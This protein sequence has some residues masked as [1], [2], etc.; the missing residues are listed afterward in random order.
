MKHTWINCRTMLAHLQLEDYWIEEL[1]FRDVGLPSSDSPSNRPALP[2]VEFTVSP[3]DADD[4][5]QVFFVGLRVV[6]GKAQVLRGVP[7]EFRIQV[8]GVF[9]VS[10]D[11]KDE[12]ARYRLV[13]LNGPAMLYGIARSAI[14]TVT[15]MGHKTKYIL[16]SI[17]II[18]VWKRQQR[19][20]KRLAPER[21]ILD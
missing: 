19:R 16:P 14:G 12:A 13:H 20:A 4:D 21:V 7:Y 15:A 6:A 5:E 2:R 1:T 11:V 9:T 17:N 3:S 18:D 10:D 8:S